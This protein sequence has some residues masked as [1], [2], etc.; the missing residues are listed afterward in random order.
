[1]K[2]RYLAIENYRSKS[3]V[4]TPS[5]HN[6]DVFSFDENERSA[7]IN[8]LHIGNGAIVQAYTFEYK[9]RLDESKE[10]LL[11]LGI[12]E[13]RMRFK[14]SA[15]E[16]IVP[17]L[18][19][20]ELMEQFTFTIPQKGDKRKLLDLSIQNVRQFKVDRLKQAEKLNPEQRTTRI[21]STIQKDL[22]MHELP[23][24]I[25]CFDNSNIQ[26]TNPVAACVVFKKAKP[27][28]KDYRQI[29]S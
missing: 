2:E 12:I 23:M 28:K 7:F 26:G 16:I 13:M 24:H 8:Y 14:S 15:R 25:E 20:T 27:S 29:L 22:H 18:P 9:K 19:D 17:F 1:M 4:V 3:T 6:I 11:G 10:E 21:L 5:L